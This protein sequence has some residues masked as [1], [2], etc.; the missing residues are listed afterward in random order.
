MRL[1]A[2]VLGVAEKDTVC[3]QCNFHTPAGVRETALRVLNHAYSPSLRLNLDDLVDKVARLYGIERPV[4]DAVKH[5]Q[6]QENVGLLLENPVTEMRFKCHDITIDVCRELDDIE[7]ADHSFM[8][9]SVK[10]EHLYRHVRKS[11]QLDQR[12]K[13]M[14]HNV[15]RSDDSAE[16][17]LVDYR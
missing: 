6:V 8:R 9:P 13:L 3:K 2:C 16:D 5:S 4:T 15:F 7:H 17:G 10:G 14:A 12:L 11:R 1:L